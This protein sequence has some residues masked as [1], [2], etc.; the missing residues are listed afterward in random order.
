MDKT[1]A[2]R[3]MQAEENVARGELDLRRQRRVIELLEQQ[4]SHGAAAA[5]KA[6]LADFEISQHRRI[7]ERDRIEQQLAQF[8]DIAG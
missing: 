4:C 2:Q 5:A 6:L 3:L 7:T 8:A 1:L